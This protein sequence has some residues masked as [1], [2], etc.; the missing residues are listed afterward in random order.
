MDFLSIQ[1]E[2]SPVY[3]EF[4]PIQKEGS[5]VYAGFWKRS[6]ALLVDSFVLVPVGMIFL[7]LERISIWSAI[8]VTVISAIFFA[9]YVIYFHYR[10]GAT[11]G[12]MVTGIKVTLPN[13]SPIEFKEALLRS[14]VELALSVTTMVARL[15]AFIIADAEQYQ[16]LDWI[17]REEYVASL[18]PAW[19]EAVEPI[20]WFWFWSEVV[21]LLFNERKRALHDI[22]A[23]TVVIHKRFAK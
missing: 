19:H 20:Y 13:G 2:G 17:G 1:K 14:C 23:G 5:P 16:S 22:I 11:L 10:Y 18:I 12:K 3:A 9:A 21:V 6:G 8:G 4:L 15:S 7:L